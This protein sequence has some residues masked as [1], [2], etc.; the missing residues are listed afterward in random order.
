MS[1]EKVY[2]YISVF[3]KAGEA[4]VKDLPFVNQPTLQMLH[5]I[6]AAAD[7]DPMYDEYPIDARIA[8]RLAPLVQEPF[9]L[10]RFEYFLSCDG[11]A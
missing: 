11:E 7:D 8:L 10:E 4:H 9:D 6:F 5:G 1:D 3:E 2:R